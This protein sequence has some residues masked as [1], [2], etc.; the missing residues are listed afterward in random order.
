MRAAKLLPLCQLS[1][2][3]ISLTPQVTD[4]IPPTVLHTPS[5][6]SN[7]ENLPLHYLH[8]PPPSKHGKEASLPYTRD[9]RLVAQRIRAVDITGKADRC[10]AS[11]DPRNQ[12]HKTY[13]GARL[14]LC[15]SPN[16]R[17]AHIRTTAQHKHVRHLYLAYAAFR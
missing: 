5:H 10:F 7:R 17:F 16:E 11:R 8:T 4:V 2:L 6:E 3:A 13:L 14:P 15:R 9:H 12:R 1:P